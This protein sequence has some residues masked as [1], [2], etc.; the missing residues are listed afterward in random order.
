MEVT[1]VVQ[2]KGNKEQAYK[3]GPV[4]AE[5]QKQFKTQIQQNTSAMKS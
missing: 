1:P 3:I 4:T 5:L 2:L